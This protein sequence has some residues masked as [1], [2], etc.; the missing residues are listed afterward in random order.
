M[1][2]RKIFVG[3][4]IPQEIRKRLGKRL[5]GWKDL[6]LRRTKE[7]NLHV[8][9][10]FIGFRNDEDIAQI[11]SRLRETVRSEEPFDIF[12]DR[13]AR[14]PETGKSARSLLWYFG[15]ESEELLLLSNRIRVA[16]DI[17]VR[18]RKHFRPHITLARIRKDM[19]G[20]LSQKPDM[21]SSWAASVPVSSL[22]LFESIFSK[23]DGLSYEAL[24]EFPLEGESASQKSASDAN[25]ASLE[26]K[27]S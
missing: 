21:E 14:M 22:I 2:A 7:K 15:P 18:P 4:S 3:F 6:P 25:N 27:D 24:E 11:A 10:L 13:I 20:E 16:L 12:F 23:E 1:K 26:G 9:L 19:W 5:E 17:G 8:T